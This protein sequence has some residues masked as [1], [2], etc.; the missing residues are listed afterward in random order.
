[1]VHK[2]RIFSLLCEASLKTDISFSDFNTMAYMHKISRN[3][4]K[5]VDNANNT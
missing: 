4:N 1:M 2:W 5:I 3:I